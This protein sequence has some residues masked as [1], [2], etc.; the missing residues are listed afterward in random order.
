MET[1]RVRALKNAE[2]VLSKVM[3]LG[4]QVADEDF[5][6]QL[7]STNTTLRKEKVLI[8]SNSK[9]ELGLV[10]L[11]CKAA[12]ALGL[13]WQ[14]L[15]YDDT[16][17]LEVI[18][19]EKKI[20]EY[21]QRVELAKADVCIRLATDCVNMCRSLCDYAS[22]VGLRTAEM[23]GLTIDSLA[24]PA[25]TESPEAMLQRET[26]LLNYLHD[27]RWLI[28]SS[29]DGTF[30]QIGLDPSEPWQSDPSSFR[31]FYEDGTVPVD[32]FP[33]RELYKNVARQEVE[34]QVVLDALDTYV[35]PFGIVDSPVVLKFHHGR[36]VLI[37]GANSAR[38]LIRYISETSKGDMDCDAAFG[39]GEIAIGLNYKA[40]WYS[41]ALSIP[42][43]IVEKSPRFHFALGASS[44]WNSCLVNLANVAYSAVHLDIV[45]LRKHQVG[46]IYPDGSQRLLFGAAGSIERYGQSA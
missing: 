1:L 20:E 36:L 14:H 30:L 15:F 41:R 13:E 38:R 34:G 32:N 27:I 45:L 39:V 22:S 43:L 42:T 23:P 26:E 10:D 44:I 37:E 16:V 33:G 35:E 46:A 28:F 4:S 7:S 8:V 5:F 6:S 24:S 2:F 25:I 40:D 17:P 9:T 12:Q 11:W 29:G 19:E 3:G 31:G 21:I 18:D